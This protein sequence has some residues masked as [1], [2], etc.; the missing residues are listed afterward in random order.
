LIGAFNGANLSVTNDDR[1]PAPKLADL[2]EG[3]TALAVYDDF[4]VYTTKEGDRVM[5]SRVIES[6]SYQNLFSTG[7]IDKLYGGFKF[8]DGMIDV[9]AAVKSNWRNHWNSG[10]MMGIDSYAV[11][12]EGNFMSVNVKPISA[13]QVGFILPG[14]FDFALSGWA[15]NRAQTEQNAYTDLT[16]IND[17]NSSGY[18][19]LLN[20]GYRRFIQDSLERMT[21]GAKYEAGLLNVALQYGLRGRPGFYRYQDTN[22]IRDANFLNSVLYAEAQLG[23]NDAM[24][25]ELEVR[26]EFFK[27][28][29]NGTNID[30][31]PNRTVAD[32]RSNV[33]AEFED[34]SRTALAIGAGFQ[35]TASPLQ[36][37]LRVIYF[38]DIWTAGP[39]YGGGGIGS[40]NARGVENGLVRFEPYVHY[41]IVPSTLRFSLRTRLDLPLSEWYLARY[42]QYDQGY[43]NDIAEGDDWRGRAN[44]GN[45]VNIR[46]YTLG[47]EVLP[48]LFFNFMETGATSGVNMDSGFTGIV[49]RYRLAGLMFTGGQLW[50]KYAGNP[51]RNAFDVIFRWS[52]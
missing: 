9:Q 29:D 11:V 34:V 13:L 24:R 45:N 40:V 33:E 39:L 8:L 19:Y 16:G 51:T 31:T 15:A 44:V 10:Q 2:P 7:A 1:T 42:D 36:A 41:D 17:V 5:V 4:Y 52:F 25:A 37:R 50:H 6:W 20:N 43:K 22:T 38:N 48:Q 27:S 30:G 3:A 32:D 49:A 28:F 23:I 14:I 26:G 12:Q 46:A 18:A 35:Y 47:Y 21:F